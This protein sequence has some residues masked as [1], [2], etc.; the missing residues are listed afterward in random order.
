MK[1]KG[2][3]ISLMRP[4]FINNEKMDY[5]NVCCICCC[6]KDEERSMDL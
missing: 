2:L 6:C 3:E 1:N 5:G 4:V